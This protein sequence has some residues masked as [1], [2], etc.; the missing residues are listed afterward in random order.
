MK[1]A[2][3]KNGASLFSKLVQNSKSKFPFT[4]TYERKLFII[5][6]HLVFGITRVTL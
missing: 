2:A 3:E 1:A 5:Q 4:V 6:K